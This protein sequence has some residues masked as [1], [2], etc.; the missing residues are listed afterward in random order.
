MVKLKVVY[1]CADC[2]SLAPKWVGKCAS[3]NGWNTLFEDVEAVASASSAT[4]KV[5]DAK[6]SQVDPVSIDS[7]DTSATTV[8]STGLDEVDRVVGGGLVPGSVTVLGGEPGI[9]KSTL[10]LQMLAAI[11]RQGQRVLL[12]CGEESVEQVSR[13]AQ[14]LAAVD[15]NLFVV[16]ETSTDAVAT[17]IA[18]IK[19]VVVVV[20]SI[21][22]MS[23]ADSDAVAGSIT[24]V[25]QSAHTLTDLAKDQGVAMI[26]VGHVTKE[27]SLAGPRVLEHLVDTVLHFE[28]DRHHGL[29]LL[30]AVKHRFG[31]TGELGVFEMTE[32]GLVALDDPS[33]LFLADR[34]VTTPGSIV[35]PILDGSRPLLVEV[36]ALVGPS[37]TTLPRRNAQ[38]LDTSRLSLLCAV[39]QRHTGLALAN[40]DVYASV[41]GG[42]NVS[43]PAVDLGVALAIVSATF[44]VPLPVGLVA[45]GEVGLA[46]EIRHVGQ[47]PRRLSEASRLGFSDALVPPSGVVRPTSQTLSLVEY[48]EDALTVNPVGTLIEAIMAC[49]MAGYFARR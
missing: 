42:V 17:A 40:Q 7:I 31:S 8:V 9:G 36:Q 22:T 29:R 35:V 24:A 41:I 6:A 49:E 4:R 16:A 18:Q 2:G 13:R 38:G 46:G 47:L 45:C 1:R 10:V 32:L 27:G 33:A 5:A 37:S 43:E 15:S 20:D 34:R 14:R 39:L 23:D 21:Q 30:R 12:V 28:G 19:P 44:G 11:A 26:L 25:R 3:C 48:D